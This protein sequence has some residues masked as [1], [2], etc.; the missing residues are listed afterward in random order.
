MT[1]DTRSHPKNCYDPRVVTRLHEARYQFRHP[2]M[3]SLLFRD[4]GDRLYTLV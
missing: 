2:V 1:S 3:F 4:L